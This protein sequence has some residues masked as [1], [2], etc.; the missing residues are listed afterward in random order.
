MYLWNQL[1][2]F[3]FALNEFFDILSI[4]LKEYN[5]LILNNKLI[6][7]NYLVFKFIS[8]IGYYL[9]HNLDIMDYC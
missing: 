7:D 6:C 2:V 8:N 3:S 4:S 1:L 9:E 5:I